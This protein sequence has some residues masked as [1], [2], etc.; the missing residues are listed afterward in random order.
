M[1]EYVYEAVPVADV[2]WR[3]KA[4]KQPAHS[5]LLNC[6]VEQERADFMQSSLRK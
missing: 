1:P 6:F 2:Q 3:N 5:A 4:I